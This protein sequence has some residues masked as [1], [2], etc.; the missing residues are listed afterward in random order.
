MA[1][2][3]IFGMVSLSINKRFKEV[4]IRKVLGASVTNISI[5]FVKDFLIVLVIS[6][7]IACP[8]AYLITNQWLDNYAYRIDIGFNPFVIGIL[9]V[10]CITILLV[11]FQTLKVAITNPV[12]SLKSE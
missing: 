8:I 7:L 6:I 12:N 2:L 9:L 3:G 1:L 5:L 4:G 10:G 11:V